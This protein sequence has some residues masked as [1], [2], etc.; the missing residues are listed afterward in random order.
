MATY[1]GPSSRLLIDIALEGVLPRRKNI[2]LLI[3][4]LGRGFSL[5]QALSYPEIK[6]V[7]VVELEPK[8]VTWNRVHLGNSDI[9]DD[10]RTEIVVGDFSGYISGNPRNYN[11]IA[12]GINNGPNYMKQSQNRWASLSMLQ[13]LKARLR[14]EGTLAIWAQTASSP[15]EQALREVF[16][17]VRLLNSPD[18]DHEGNPVK[19]I[20]YGAKP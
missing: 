15:Y 17:Q 16:N 6:M 7:C 20:I 8:I 9:L 14:S 4:G 3:G 13:I 11:G 10:P 19:N 18:S 2:E 12:I 1:A 5:R